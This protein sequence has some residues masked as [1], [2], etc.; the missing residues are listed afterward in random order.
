MKHFFL[1]VISVTFLFNLQAQ[2]PAKYWVQFKD[3]AGSPY[4]I[5]RPEEFLSPRA[6]EKRAR[7]DIEITE[8]DLPVNESYIR[9]LLAIDPNMVLLTKS[10]WFNGVTV[11]TTTADIQGKITELPFVNLCECTV[12]LEQEETFDYPKTSYSAPSKV[13]EVLT[14]TPGKDL[15]YGYC[16]KQVGINNAHWLHRLGAHGEGMLMMVLDAG[17][18]NA[19]SISHFKALREEGRL[20]GTRSFVFPGR[21]VFISGSHGTMVLSCITGYK[22]DELMGTAPKADFYLAQTE[23]ERTEN[24]I[25][26]DNWV[27]AAE[28]ADSLGCDVINSSL[29]YYKFDNKAQSYRYED[30]DGQVSRASQAGTIAASKGIIVCVSAGNEGDEDWHYITCPADAKDALTVGAIYPNGTAADFSS[31]GPTSD[32]RVK[33]DGAAVGAYAIVAEP[34][35]E[36]DVSFGTSFSSPIFSGMVACLWQLFPEKSNYEIMEAIRIAGHQHSHPTDHLGYGITNFMEAYNYLLRDLNSEILMVFPSHASKSTCKAGYISWK[37]CPSFSIEV[38]MDGSSEILRQEIR[39][40]GEKMSGGGIYGEPKIK[41]PKLPKEMDYGIARIK[42][43]TPDGKS[44]EQVVGL[45]H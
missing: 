35:D 15:N 28:W 36:T 5:E 34:S 17:F 12:Q 38:R 41:L 43:I 8:Q 18:E 20:H 9:Q 1:W 2:T 45:H 44:Y 16:A 30:M 37:G 6:I 11:Y 25:E 40:K 19:N 42:I 33:P 3:K 27:A 4:S 22:E 24:K 29:G 13:K 26:E 39:V 14:V 21:S 10:K 7:F 31:Y 23:D 32:G